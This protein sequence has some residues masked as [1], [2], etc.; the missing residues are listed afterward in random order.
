MEA[1]YNVGTVIDAFVEAE[2]ALPC[3]RLDLVGSGSERPALERRARETVAAR[4]VAFTGEIAHEKM[5]RL[6]RE[7]DIFISVA[8]SDTTSVSLL[9]A[10][11]C[12]LFPVVSDLPAN[13]EWI[14]DG[15]NGLVVPAQDT[16]SLARAII[17]A[18]NDPAL[19][20]AARKKN[21]GLIETRA[22]WHRNM[23]IV[24]DLFRR[25]ATLS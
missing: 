22:D 24:N 12:G 13:R 21:A 4:A 6:L 3:A 25:L 2:K 9:E 10:M 20:D 17:R 11:A 14:D 18:A 19:R 7:N 23:S 8:L 5:P 1:V 15:V 16:A